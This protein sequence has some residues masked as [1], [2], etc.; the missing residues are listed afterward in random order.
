MA[1]KPGSIVHVEIHSP[2]PE[3]T[4]RFYEEVFGWKFES[5]PQ[6]NYTTF[7]A[8]SPPDGGL[9]TPMEGMGPTVLNYLLSTD[10]DETQRK[11]ERAG[12]SVVVRKSE[13]PNF[14]WFAIFRDPVGNHP[15]AL[16]EH[17]AAAGR[18]SAQGEAG[19]Q[20]TSSKV[21]GSPRP[22]GGPRRSRL[23]PTPR[24][25]FRGPDDGPVHVCSRVRAEE[26]DELGDVLGR[27][28]LSTLPW[29]AMTDRVERL[30]EGDVGDVSR[31]HRVDRD[32]LVALDFRQDAGESMAGDLANR[33]VIRRARE[34]LGSLH[35]DVHNASPAFAP[36]VG[37][38]RFDRVEHAV[39]FRAQNTLPESV[40]DLREI[41]SRIPLASRV[42]DQYVHRPEVAL[43]MSEHGPYLCPA[44]CVRA[45][46]GGPHAELLDRPNQ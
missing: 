28:V 32:A 45:D 12:G 6:M 1:H 14:G 38:G 10:I 16:P 2:A 41:P 8:P 37:E 33:V 20:S 7:K 40:I 4:Q 23:R 30:A 35:P 36:H 18:P 31:G 26:C 43:R 3:K 27:P 24:T 34:L 5:I 46:E 11:I 15:G 22:V 13:I 25:V 42:V 29:A 17:A 9:I 21:Q 39:N 19:E 44:R